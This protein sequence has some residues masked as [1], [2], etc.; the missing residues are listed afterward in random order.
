MSRQPILGRE[1]PSV[2]TTGMKRLGT[3][4]AIG[5]A[6]PMTA[7]SGAG[8][9]SSKPSNTQAGVE[10]GSSSGSILEPKTET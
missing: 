10:T 5:G 2:P 3:T 8:F 4:N 7:V 1:N 9:S 6:R